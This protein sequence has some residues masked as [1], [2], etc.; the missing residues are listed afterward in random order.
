MTEADANQMPPEFTSMKE[1]ISTFSSSVT[2]TKYPITNIGSKAFKDK[3]LT[4]VEIGN[5][6]TSIGTQAFYENKLSILVIPSSVTTMGSFAFGDHTNTI[7]NVTYQNSLTSVTMYPTK[8]VLGS[9]IVHY[10][11]GYDP[12]ANCE[13]TILDDYS[14]NSC[15][16]WVNG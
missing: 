9:Q 15:I 7:E 10:M 6:I 13:N 3:G 12:N 4:S 14:S 1:Y 16:T 5:G 8:Q 2:D 11:F